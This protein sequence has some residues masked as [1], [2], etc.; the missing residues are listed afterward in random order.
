MKIWDYIKS[1]LLNKKKA[2]PEPK[3][4]IDENN[5]SILT[6][7]SGKKSFDERIKVDIDIKPNT[8]ESAIDKYI[9]A[10]MKADIPFNELSTYNVLIR[11]GALPNIDDGNSFYNQKKFIEDVNKDL[12]GYR[13]DVKSDMEMNENA[14]KN[15][16]Y[17]ATND[18]NKSAE[19]IKYRIYLNCEKTNVVELASRFAKELEN[20]D[21]YF[22]FGAAENE[23]E[24]SEKFVFYL[25]DEEDLE[26][27]IAVI[28]K[29]NREKPELFKNA[30]SVNPFLKNRNGYIAYA[31]EIHKGIYNNLIGETKVIDKSYNTLLSEA[32]QDS[33]LEAT[34]EIAMEDFD[35]AIESGVYNFTNIR[36]LY[37]SK[38]LDC[39]YY[40]QSLK[41]KAIDL[42]KKKLEIISEKNPELD[43]KGI[44]TKSKNL[45]KNIADYTQE[46]Y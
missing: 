45:G 19:D 6:S 20:Q 46:S 4:E 22:K 27:K 30:H 17:H 28:N 11:I 5:Q 21:F 35:M 40:D 2:L 29:V 43:I 13:L 34:K 8:I 12:Y 14:T 18:W 32:L 23:S 42:I 24:R 36:Q 10:I 7:T 9:L 3:N 39:I 33:L 37:Q 25:E 26:Q 38:L 44:N 41:S 31:P 15:D 16:F 1:K